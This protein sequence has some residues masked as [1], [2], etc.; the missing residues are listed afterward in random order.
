RNTGGA[1]RFARGE[2]PDPSAADVPL[3]DE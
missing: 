1:G 2:A 3:L